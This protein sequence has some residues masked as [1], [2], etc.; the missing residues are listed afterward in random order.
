MMT[1]YA[2]CMLAKHHG[3]WFYTC[4]QNGYRGASTLQVKVTT[5]PDLSSL[6]KYHAGSRAEDIQ[7]GTKYAKVAK[8]Q[9]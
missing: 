7:V 2:T 3:K 5:F 9:R 8:Y 4:V 6:E 1:Q